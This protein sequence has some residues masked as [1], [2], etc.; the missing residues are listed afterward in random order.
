MTSSMENCSIRQIKL[1]T[2]ENI[3]VTIDLDELAIL[4][5]LLSVW[6]NINVFYCW[7]HFCQN[8]WKNI[9]T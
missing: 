2:F 4:N 1:N 9:Q 6:P 8:L 3:E 7:F 5:A